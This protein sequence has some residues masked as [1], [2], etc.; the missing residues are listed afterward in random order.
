MPPGTR[1]GCRRIT[2]AAV[3]TAAAFIAPGPLAARE[4]A[5]SQ[6][7]GSVTAALLYN[8]A[9]FTEWPALPPGAPIAMCVVADVGMTDVVAA[10]VKGQ[11]INGHPVL[12]SQPPDSAAWSNCQVLFI[13]D[14]EARR[15]AEALARIRSN[16][17]LTV[18][19]GRSFAKTGGIIELY[20]D[21]GKMRFAINV[22]AA[23]R[24]GVRLSSRLLGL[25]KIVRNDSGT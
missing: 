20:V 15:L 11:Q 8:F 13:A 16:P 4:V 1:A 7:E 3:L 21:S 12:V 17:V 19:N 9:K 18:S 2:V 25:A 6:S 14:S 24:A 10:T 22:E 5:Q 23:E